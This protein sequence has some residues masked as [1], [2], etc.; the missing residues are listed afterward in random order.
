MT[1][2]IRPHEVGKGRSDRCELSGG[3]STTNSRN[4]RAAL[5]YAQRTWAVFPLQGKVP[6]KGSNGVH[7]AT[8]SSD[9]IVAWWSQ[10]PTA[11]IGVRTGPESRIWVLDIDPKHGGGM[12][13]EMLMEEHGSLP[14][15]P[16]QDTGGGG[17]HYVFS[18][19]TNGREVRNSAGK[20]GPGIDVRGVGGYVV[21]PPSVHPDTKREYVWD[22][23]DHPLKI[24]PAA[25]PE[26]LLDLT[27]ERGTTSH[28]KAP[29]EWAA[30]ARP[31]REGNRNHALASV[32]GKLLRDLDDIYLA[33]FLSRLYGEACFPPMNADEVD[34][35]INSILGREAQRL[36][37]GGP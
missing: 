21:V 11:N 30:L 33:I 18:W 36:E 12:T 28:R 14:A 20:V 35:T 24:E 17:E 27:A 34:R 3:N 5:W 31:Q 16:R 8:T 19:P 26:W 13:L 15:T 9:R 22:E 37:R 10:H 29:E 2:E 25:A 6:F 7:D 32:C 4:C 23:D 1:R